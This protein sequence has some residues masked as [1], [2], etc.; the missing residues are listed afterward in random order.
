MAVLHMYFMGMHERRQTSKLGERQVFQNDWELFKEL[1]EKSGHTFIGIYTKSQTDVPEKI[2][3][4]DLEKFISYKS[5]RGITNVNYPEGI[6]RR[7]LNL[8][9]FKGQGDSYAT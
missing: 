4:Y 9:V 2:S 6:N 8:V 1:L 3:Q 7:R 5:E